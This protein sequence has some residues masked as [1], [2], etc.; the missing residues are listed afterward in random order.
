MLDVA[1]EISPP[2]RRLGARWLCA[3]GCLFT[4]RTR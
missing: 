3:G 2:G 1:K 4:L